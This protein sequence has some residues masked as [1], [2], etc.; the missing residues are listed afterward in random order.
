VSK[1]VEKIRI[2]FCRSVNLA[3]WLDL[4]IQINSLQKSVFHLMVFVFIAEDTVCQLISKDHIVF[5][6]AKTIYQGA[7]FANI[8]IG[9]N[10]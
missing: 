5:C 4:H 8:V 7:K 3:L 10:N 1:K 9:V 6:I 2:I